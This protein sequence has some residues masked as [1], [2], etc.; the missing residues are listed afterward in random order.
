MHPLWYLFFFFVW[1]LKHTSPPGQLQPDP[2]RFPSGMASLASYVHSKGLKFGLYGDAGTATC[3][4]YA[5][6]EGYEA[7]DA[8]TLAAWGV[9]Y[10]KLDGCN[11]PVSD[12]QYRYTLWSQELAKQNRSIVFSCSWP[13]YDPSA[14]LTYVASI[15]NLWREYDDI[16]DNFAAFMNILD[17]QSTKGLAPYA[18]P[19]HWNDPDM[20]EVGNGGC[21]DT[22]YTTLFSMWAILAAP[23]IAGN[24][25]RNMSSATLAILAAPEVIAVDQ[26][27]L[28]VE[29]VLL[30]NV[31]TATG[32]LQV[33]ARPLST[34]A[35]ATA[36]VNRSAAPANITVSWTSFGIPP[37]APLMARDLWK[38]QTSG[39]YVGYYTAVAVPSHGT[40][41]LSFTAKDQ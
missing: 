21:T 38:Q 17:Y 30:S 8:A 2:S 4:G 24:D 12:M 40:A 37:S 3:G 31:S 10:W 14:N 1:I 34:G 11:L 39:P 26:D 22:E 9:D 41:L 15:C 16:T 35:I 29:G 6:S 13:A 25:L 18:G 27:A 33:W 36:F 7:I 32:P 5:G 28:G 19:G 23:L 20:L